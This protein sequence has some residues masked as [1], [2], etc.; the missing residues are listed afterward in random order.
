MGTCRRISAALWVVFEQVTV[1]FVMD[2]V[3]R[4]FGFDGG[5]SRVGRGAV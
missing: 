2:L 5:E 1:L 4:T 3:G